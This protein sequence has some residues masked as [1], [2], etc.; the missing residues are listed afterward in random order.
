MQA[1]SH[2]GILALL[3]FVPTQASCGPSGP[4]TAPLSRDERSECFDV[5]TRTI[6]ENFYD[7]LFGGVAWRAVTA[8]YHPQAMRAEGDRACGHCDSCTIRR[9]GFEEAGVPDPTP[10]ASD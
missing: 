3:L 4:R 2:P 9:R 6:S 10:Y 8:R 1:M 5:V 7:P